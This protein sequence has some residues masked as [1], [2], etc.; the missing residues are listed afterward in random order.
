MQVHSPVVRQALGMWPHRQRAVTDHAGLLATLLA[1]L[2]DRNNEI[3]QR[4]DHEQRSYLSHFTSLITVLLAVAAADRFGGLL[5]TGLQ[6][7]LPSL[8]LGLA[9]FLLWLPLDAINEQFRIRLVAVYVYRDLRPQILEAINQD[10]AS[11]EVL[12]WEK[13]QSTATVR[14]GLASPFVSAMLVFRSVVGYAPSIVVVLYYVFGSGPMRT[15]ELI[16]IEI[17]LLV[18]W[19]VVAIVP[20]SVATLLINHEQFRTGP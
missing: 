1:D 4:T 9:I 6:A 14:L 10:V 5:S 19:V 3:R 18:I 17:L 2:A 16:W 12:Q 15:G 13:M 20:L 8:A 7:Y 11:S